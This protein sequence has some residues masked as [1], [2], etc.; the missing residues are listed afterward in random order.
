VGARQPARRELVVVSNRE[1]YSHVK[2]D[3]GI[4]WIRKRGGM[5]WPSTRSPRRSRGVDR[6]WQRKRRSRHRRRRGSGRVSSDRPRYTLKRC[7][8]RGKDQ[9]LYY[10]GFSNGALWPLCHIATCARASAP[11]SGRLPRGQPHVREA[12]LEEVGDRP[13]LVFIQDITWRWWPG[14]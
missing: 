13:A 5:T 3:D 8:S 12:V 7:G 9:E 11:T 1:P 2:S 10:S 4:R 14:S 6:P